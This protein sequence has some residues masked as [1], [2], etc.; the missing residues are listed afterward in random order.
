MEWFCRVEP[1][2]PQEEISAR[3]TLCSLPEQCASIYKVENI[4]ADRLSAQIE[5][6]WGIF[7]VV[8]TPIRN[9]VRYALANCPNALQWTI[10]SDREGTLIHCS[11]N[12]ETTDPDFADSIQQLMENFRLYLS[13]Q[14]TEQ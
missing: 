1:P 10:T 9:G 12:Q 11:I 14:K 2:L 4:S 3:C 7:T 13:C 8:F 5:C 6:V